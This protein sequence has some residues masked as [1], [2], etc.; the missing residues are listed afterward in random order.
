MKPARAVPSFGELYFQPIKEDGETVEGYRDRLENIQ[1]KVA[2]SP[3][4]DQKLSPGSFVLLTQRNQEGYTGG[5]HFDDELAAIDRRRKEVYLNI[6]RYKALLDEAAKRGNREDENTYANLIAIQE[7]ELDDLS[8]ATHTLTEA[9]GEHYMR[10]RTGK[11]FATTP[12]KMRDASLNNTL[13]LVAQLKG[14]EFGSEIRSKQIKEASENEE[15]IRQLEGELSEQRAN[16]KE[17]FKERLPQEIRDSLINIQTAISRM[18]EYYD[19]GETGALDIPVQDEVERMIADLERLIDGSALQKKDSVLPKTPAE[20]LSEIQASGED[21]TKET[22]MS[23]KLSS[24]DAEKLIELLK[25]QGII[26]NGS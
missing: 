16:I 14:K 6:T 13:G 10:R 9:G 2:R 8:A 21:I 12:R 15:K 25:E 19:S 5:T 26:N 18:K 1:E 22:L 3:V 11:E 17:L 20:V 24:E 7:R 23:R 4:K